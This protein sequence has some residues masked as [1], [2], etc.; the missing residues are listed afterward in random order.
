MEVSEKTPGRAGILAPVRRTT[1]DRLAE[2][3]GER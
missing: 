1:L 2:T 3:V